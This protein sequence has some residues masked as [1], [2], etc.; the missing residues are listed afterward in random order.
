MP[1]WGLVGE[2]KQHDMSNT[3]AHYTS[4]DAMLNIIRGDG[5]HFRAT[6]FT[7][8][9]DSLEFKWP[10]EA[11]KEKVKKLEGMTDEEVSLCYEK[12]PYVISLS[13]E[14]DDHLL[15]HLY[16]K[17]GYGVSMVLDKEL[18]KKNP[19][20]LIG[21]FN[22]NGNR[23]VLLNMKYA[24][25]YNRLSVLSEIE[26]NYVN[27]GYG[28]VNDDSDDAF[29]CCSFLK[30]DEWQCEK[31]VRYAVIRDKTVHAHYNPESESKCDMS[32]SEDI[33]DVKYY[34]RGSE[35]VPYLDVFL[36]KKA[37]TAIV[38]GSRLNF[39]ET[40][41]NIENALHELGGGYE[42]V[43]IVKSKTFF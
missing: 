35:F 39:E 34:A 24:N 14:K 23:H 22:N 21:E 1:T 41:S 42:N 3:L 29:I 31:E 11:L 5:L 19:T 36:P 15:W 13:D 38:V 27:E 9:N 37:L 17:C 4:L 30:R 10:Y 40:K 16:G 20:D 2:Q 8:L 26:E 12:F 43:D 28:T 33:H 6:H 18:L 32:G 25:E 7:K